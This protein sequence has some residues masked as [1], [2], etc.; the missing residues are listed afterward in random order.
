MNLFESLKNLITKN[1]IKT[2]NL[3]KLKVKSEN[4]ALWI[5]NNIKSPYE[6]DNTEI[7]ETTKPEKIVCEEIITK[8]IEKKEINK[9]TIEKNIKYE[10]KEQLKEEKEKVLEEK[11]K[12]QPNKEELVKSEELVKK[13]ISEISKGPGKYDI[14]TIE[15]C[16]I[17]AENLNINIRSCELIKNLIE[18]QINILEKKGSGNHWKEEYTDMVQD[19][20]ILFLTPYTHSKLLGDNQEQINKLRQRVRELNRNYC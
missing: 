1:K 12:D 18:K 8:P 13:F 10:I 17:E 20:S 19:L 6:F 2:K 11:P 9:K 14:K 5:L 3:P 7:I 4:D 15:T 16:V